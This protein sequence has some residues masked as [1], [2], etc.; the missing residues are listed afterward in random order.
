LTRLDWRVRS[1]GG[2]NFID[3]SNRT[4]GDKPALISRVIWR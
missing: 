1:V 2:G 4:R 3:C